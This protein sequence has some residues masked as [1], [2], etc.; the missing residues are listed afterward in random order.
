M[1]HQAARSGRAWHH[2]RGPRPVRRRGADGARE[3]RA[4]SSLRIVE[5]TLVAGEPN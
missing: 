1:A 5:R 2:W 4:A 3:Q